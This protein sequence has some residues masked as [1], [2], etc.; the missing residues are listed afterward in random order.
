MRIVAL[1]C[2]HAMLLW[3]SNFLLWQLWV[4]VLMLHDKH[5]LLLLRL[6]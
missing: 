3:K 1:M 5:R 2:W 6:L 4:L